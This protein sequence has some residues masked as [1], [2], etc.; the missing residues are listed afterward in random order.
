M[1]H[2]H[3][4]DKY[5]QGILEGVKTIAIIGASIKPSR[6]SFTVTQYMISKGYEV[7]PVN[8]GYAGRKIAGRLCYATMKDIPKPIDM[9]DIFRNSEAVYGVVEEALDLI[10]L[11]KVI[12]LQLDIINQ[13]AAE[14]AEA[15][16][17]QVVMDRCP[18]TEHNRL[19]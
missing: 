18:K 1:N 11:P 7:F 19:Y 6:A 12:W 10:P 9:V 13:N 8:P 14:L 17:L 15:K 4:E 3:Y 16:G 5:I 2:D